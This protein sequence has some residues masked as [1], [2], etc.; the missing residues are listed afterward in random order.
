MQFH[1]ADSQHYELQ[2]KQLY[3]QVTIRHKKLGSHIHYINLMEYQ[4]LQ[5]Q[6]YLHNS[7]KIHEK[8]IEKLLN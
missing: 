7:Q 8:L 4:K 5:I 6:H 3:H 2:S 1:Q